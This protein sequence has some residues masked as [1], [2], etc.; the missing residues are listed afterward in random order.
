M[1][2]WDSAEFKSTETTSSN[3][4]RSMPTTQWNVVTT[5]GRSGSPESNAALAKLCET[6]WYPLYTF[7]RRSGQGPEDAQ[8]LTQEFFA[9]L[10][11]KNYVEVADPYDASFHFR[12]CNTAGCLQQMSA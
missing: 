1:K 9:R 5:A 8:D 2:A 10:I 3:E 4:D 12:K 11:E 7:I 6:Y